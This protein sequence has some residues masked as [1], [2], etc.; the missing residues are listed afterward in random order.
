MSEIERV[1]EIIEPHVDDMGFDLVRVKFT[2]TGKYKTLQIMA[3]P[4]EGAKQMSVDDCEAISTRVS[5]LLDVEDVIKG[6]Y[7]LE[8]SS[9]GL[10]R[11]LVREKDFE[12]FAESLVKIKTEEPVNGQRNFKGRLK[13]LKDGNVQ[14]E[15]DGILKNVPFAEI[16]SAEIE[17]E[18]P[19]APKPKKGKRK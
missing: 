12:R 19:N 2:G 13:G 17:W 4:K 5:A 18:N 3:E 11:P 15:E 14:I 16:G 1:K 6:H 8:V 7:T 10:D 9:P